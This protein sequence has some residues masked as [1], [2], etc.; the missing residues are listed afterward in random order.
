L[1]GWYDYS[2]GLPGK[3]LMEM[4]MDYHTCRWPSGMGAREIAAHFLAMNAEQAPDGAGKIITFSHFMPRIDLM[5]ATVP[6]EKQLLYPILGSTQLD[7]QLRKLR[8][9]VHVYGHSHVNRRLQ[10]DGVTYIN[11]AFGYPQEER[12]ASKRLVCIET[13]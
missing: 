6:P 10:I 2:F 9:T 5:P 13:V 3:E 8:S 4:W 11:N 7:R 12:I 1:F